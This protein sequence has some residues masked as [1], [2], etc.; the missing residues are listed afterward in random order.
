MAKPDRIESS[1]ENE[2]KGGE[3]IKSRVGTL[4]VVGLL[5][6]AIMFAMAIPVAAQ[7]DLKVT[8]EN[9]YWLWSFTYGNYQTGAWHPYSYGHLLNYGH[10]VALNTYGKSETRVYVGSIPA[11]KIGNGECV[12]F[13]KAMSNTGGISS[14][15]WERGNRVFD[16]GSITRGTVIATFSNPDTYYG[17]VAVFDRWHWTYSGGWIV[18]GFYVWDQNYLPDH[19]GLVAKHII[20]TNGRTLVTNANNYYV[21]RV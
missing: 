6:V 1:V 13:A 19:G 12:D 2:I 9:Q 4:L 17:H 5:F 10:G 18:D 14:I 16:D 21:V 11:I 7:S 8:G 3:K 20:K 15:N